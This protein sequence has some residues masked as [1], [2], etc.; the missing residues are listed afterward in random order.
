MTFPRPRRKGGLN[1]TGVFVGL[2]KDAISYENQTGNSGLNLSP[3]A[4]IMRMKVLRGDE[5]RKQIQMAEA[6]LVAQSGDKKVWEEFVR[7]V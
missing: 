3:R 1:L 2:V 5:K 7:N 6:F 4:L